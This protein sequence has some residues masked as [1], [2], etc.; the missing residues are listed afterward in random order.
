MHFLNG[1]KLQG[2]GILQVQNRY[3]VN[4]AN[5]RYNRTS[6][7]TWIL[8]S[9]SIISLGTCFCLCI[10][11]PG[12]STGHT[13]QCGG[14]N[15]NAWEH[16]KYFAP[17]LTILSDT[18]LSVATLFS[19]PVPSN[20]I[21]CINSAIHFT[22]TKYS[23]SSVIVQFLLTVSTKTFSHIY[24]TSGRK[25]IWNISQSNT[26]STTP[27]LI[28]TSMVKVYSCILPILYKGNLSITRLHCFKFIICDL[29]DWTFRHEQRTYIILQPARLHFSVCL[30]QDWALNIAYLF[31]YLRLQNMSITHTVKR[32]CLFVS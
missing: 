26:V 16:G 9:K 32:V 23:N 2:F 3:H 7:V 25:H 4:C 10:R 6:L 20:A 29:R 30:N 13:V 22:F 27:P 31:V 19:T 15:N 12:W 24:N 5:K 18:V 17:W 28:M 8:H 11:E 1:N 14:K 21:Q